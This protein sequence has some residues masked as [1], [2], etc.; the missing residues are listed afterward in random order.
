MWLSSSNPAP[1]SF[2]QI[3]SQ[4]AKDLADFTKPENEKQGLKCLNHMVADAL[5]HVPDVFKFMGR[6]KDQSI[7]NF[8]AIPQV[9]A[10]ATLALCYNN[11]NVF[12]TNVK[13]RKGTAVQLMLRAQNMDNLYDIFAEFIVELKAKVSASSSEA[14][15]DCHHACSHLTHTHSL[16]H[17]WYR[18]ISAS[19]RRW[20]RLSGCCSSCGRRRRPSSQPTAVEF[21]LWW[22]RLRPSWWRPAQ[23]TSLACTAAASTC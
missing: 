21:R 10:I 6:I 17:R 2:P 4:Y 15:G 8:C 11:R 20:R 5:G 23:H 1:T 22:Q 18:A 14:W 16:S 3:W 12:K 13:I 19:R 9:M 7:F